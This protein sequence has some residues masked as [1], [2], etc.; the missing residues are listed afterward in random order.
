[1]Q[2]R[3]ACRTRVQ[4][5]NQDESAFAA[6]CQSARTGNEREG[7]P[8]LSVPGPRLFPVCGSFRFYV[9]MMMTK[10]GCFGTRLS[11]GKNGETRG[12]AERVPLHPIRVIPAR[13]VSGN[14]SVSSFFQYL[15]GTRSRR[16]CAPE[17]LSRRGFVPEICFVRRACN[18]GSKR[19]YL[20]ISISV[21]CAPC[22]L[23]RLLRRHR[24]REHRCAFPIHYALPSFPRVRAR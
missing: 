16:Q 14:R 2:Q 10:Q 13:E 21:L 23:Q 17:P 3:G 15:A 20:P 1:M 5:T 22:V 8:V 24:H 12:E 11:P 18:Q 19:A 7:R 9:L 6:L 4:Q